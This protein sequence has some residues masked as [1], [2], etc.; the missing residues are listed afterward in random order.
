MAFSLD[1]QIPA[2]EY[3]GMRGGNG[4]KG[5]WLALILEDEHTNQLN[6]SVPRDM[7]AD[8]HSLGLAKGDLLVVQLRAVAMANGNS[9]IQLTALPELMDV[10]DDGQ[11]LGY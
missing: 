8:V 4:E 3:R 1:V 11:G 2:V 5:P 9:Y 10:A 6:V 7:Q